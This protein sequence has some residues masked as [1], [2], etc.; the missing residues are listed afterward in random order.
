M[1]PSTVRG[2]ALP[3]LLTSL[4]EHGLWRHPGDAAMAEVIPWFEDPLGFLPDPEQ[5]E[6]QSRSMDMFADD[7]LCAFF[8]EARGS[9]AAGPLELP[10]LD[11]EQAV[12]IAV[13]RNPGDD[14]AL[15]LDYRTDPADPRV[16]GS[17]FWTD[18]RLCQ[19]RVVAPDFSAFAA[20]LGLDVGLGLQNPQPHSSA[21]G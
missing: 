16:V 15:A 8:R 14:V 18:P 10:W 9:K 1:T 5:M 3:T 12:L 20:S 11:V 2:L 13:N 7:P 19:W 17:D 4:M 6:W 21:R